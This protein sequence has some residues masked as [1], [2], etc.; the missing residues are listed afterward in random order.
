MNCL[1]SPIYSLGPSLHREWSLEERQVRLTRRL[2]IVVGRLG[3]PAVR[4]GL[5]T[6]HPQPSEELSLAWAKD[7]ME[8]FYGV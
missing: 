4:Q 3:V 2:K 7:T 8:A 1:V 6:Y 5:T